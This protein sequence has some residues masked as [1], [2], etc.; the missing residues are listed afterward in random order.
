M[1]R[2]LSVLKQPFF[3]ILNQH[4]IDHLIL[5][6][7]S[8]RWGFGSVEHIMRDVKGGWLLRYLYANGA[9]MF[10]TAV[11]IYIFRGPYYGSYTSPREFLRF[12][13]AIVIT[14]PAS[15]VPKVGNTIVTWLWGG[16]SVDNATLNRFSNLVG[17]VAFAIFFSIWLFYAPNVLGHPD[18][19]MPANPMFIPAH[20]VLE[21]IPNKLGGVAATGP[22]FVSS[23]APPFLNISAVRS[24]SF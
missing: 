3:S 18:N 8:Y 16:F 15:A 1:A 4:L 2:R 7:L 21:C 20:I 11:H 19:Y 14:S 22:V 24:L 17:R 5:S 9:S 12:R 6:N 23:L 13:G 10:F